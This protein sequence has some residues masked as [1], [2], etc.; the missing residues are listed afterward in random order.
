MRLRPFLAAGMV[1]GLLCNLNQAEAQVQFGVRAGANFSNV[2]SKDPD[3]NK[4][5][6]TLNPGFHVGATVDIAIADEFA[7]Q[8]GLLFTQKGFQSEVITPIVTTASTATSH[9]IEVPVN[10]IFKPELGGGK[11]LLGAGPYVAYG[12]GG[13]FIRT[14]KEWYKPVEDADPVILTN[15]ENIRLQFLEDV[16]DQDA[17]KIRYSKPFDY[18]ASLLAGYELKGKYSAQLNA[19]LGL[20]NLEPTSNGSKL[21]SK[22]KNVGFGISLGYKF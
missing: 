15:K 16:N 4:A 8:P 10:L 7:L 21:G 22:F 18:G 5:D 1:A 11:L 6:F 17:N 12:V 20:A 9:H 13:R 2:I 14:R 19:Q 3:G